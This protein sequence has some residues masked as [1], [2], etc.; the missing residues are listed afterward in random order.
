MRG[1]RKEVSGYSSAQVALHWAVVV[2]IVFQ[3]VAHQGME[4]A[5]R[6]RFADEAVAADTYKLAYLHIAA[7]SAVLLLALA[8]LW[9]R[10]TRGTPPPPSDEPRIMQLFAEGVHWLIYLL[11]LLLP[12][13][14]MIGWFGDVRVVGA[15]HAFMTKLLLGAIV[16]HVAGAL[17]QHF[18][19][20]TDVLM[21]MFRPQFPP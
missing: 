6:G 10:F 11:L 13:T 9:L 18:I 21:R 4:R 3:F 15:T 20:R 1:T 7:G 14:G 19:R 5:W 16:M 12:I 8:R 2:L 17:F